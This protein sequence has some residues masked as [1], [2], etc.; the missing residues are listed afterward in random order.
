MRYVRYNLGKVKNMSKPAV[1]TVNSFKKIS[2]VHTDVAVGLVA[3]VISKKFATAEFH[4]ELRRQIELGKVRKAIM[5]LLGEED[6][7]EIETM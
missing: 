2:Q 3:R 6:W 7:T 4:Q 5:L 1:A